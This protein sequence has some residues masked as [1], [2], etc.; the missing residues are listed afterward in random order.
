MPP[1]ELVLADGS[2]YEHKGVVETV[3]GQFNR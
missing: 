1:I 2:V 3:A